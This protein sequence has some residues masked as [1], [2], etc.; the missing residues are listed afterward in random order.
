MFLSVHSFVELGKLLLDTP[1]VDFLLSEK[2]TQDP[3]KK[4]TSANNGEQAGPAT[5]TALISS[6]T[7]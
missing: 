5:N 2:L 7:I 1:D 6:A 3:L 4:N